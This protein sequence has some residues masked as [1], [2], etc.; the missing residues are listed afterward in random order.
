VVFSVNLT[1]NA[2]GAPALQT[3]LIGGNA[4]AG[5]TCPVPAAFPAALPVLV[6][7]QGDLGPAGGG[8]DTVE[9]T[10]DV[11]GGPGAAGQVI[12][13]DTATTPVV[14]AFT[15]TPCTDSVASPANSD[16]SDLTVPNTQ[17]NGVDRDVL[18]ADADLDTAVCTNSALTTCDNSAMGGDA[19]TA[20]LFVPAVVAEDLSSAGGWISQAVYVFD[21]DGGA[22]ITGLSFSGSIRADSDAVFQQP[23]GALRPG[24]T[25]TV[26]GYSGGVPGVAFD[27]Q[28]T[29]LT[30][31]T[32]TCSLGE[33]G[34]DD[35]AADGPDAMIVMVEIR[36]VNGAVG[37]VINYVATAPSCVAPG[38]CT[39]GV[40][41]PANSDGSDLTPNAAVP[42]PVVTWLLQT[43]SL[44]P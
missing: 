16:G 32:W 33:L 22:Q 12:D 7:C 10:F 37:E 38:A 19:V 36:G 39:D 24:V 27:C 34:P 29:S 13:Y 28:I 25:M 3:P 2:G 35:A 6:T 18:I 40:V 21:N 8:A 26:S 41:S 9:L 23:G 30:L 14:C 44:L 1:S 43:D 17:A 31:L 15:P 4:A 42:P 20:A 5:W 11:T